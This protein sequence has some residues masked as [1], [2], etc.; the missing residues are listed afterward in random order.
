MVATAEGEVTYTGWYSGYGNLVKISHANGVETLYGHNA[1]I[2]V[3]VGQR[4]RA[5]QLISYMGSTG[6]STG[7]HVHYEI[8]INGTPVNPVNFL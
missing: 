7:P 3:A 8:R 5:G 1:Q 2:V 4:V 6:L